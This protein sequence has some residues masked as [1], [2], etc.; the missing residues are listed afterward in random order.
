MA[1]ALRAFQAD[2]A[3]ATSMARTASA[4]LAKRRVWSVRTEVRAAER[5]ARAACAD[6]GVR[7]CAVRSP[8]GTGDCP[9]ATAALPTAPVVVPGPTA[10]PVRFAHWGSYSL[11]PVVDSLLAE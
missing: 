2:S 9:F 5:D 6:A 7:V 1:E 4:I 10:R 11:E 3:Y 8:C